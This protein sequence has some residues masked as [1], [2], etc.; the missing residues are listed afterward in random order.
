MHP[1]YLTEW[2]YLGLKHLH[3]IP[4][5]LHSSFNIFQG[6]CSLSPQILDLLTV[7]I[8]DKPAHSINLRQASSITISSLA[9]RSVIR[10]FT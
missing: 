1:H 9:R 2:I 6:K 5:W 7:Y 4:R 3:F 8:L 10:I